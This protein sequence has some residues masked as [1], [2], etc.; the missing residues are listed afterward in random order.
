[1]SPPLRAVAVGIAV[2]L[3][4]AVSSGLFGRY[5]ERHDAERAARATV[6]RERDLRE[7][8]VSRYLN[9]RHFPAGVFAGGASPGPDG[10]PG[11]RCRAWFESPT[12]DL[13]DLYAS[14]P[15]PADG[16]WAMKLLLH[17]TGRVDFT[18]RG[19]LRGGSD[20]ERA[21]AQA[22]ICTQINE[23]PRI[24]LHASDPE[25]RLVHEAIFR[26]LKAVV[27]FRDEQVAV[28]DRPAAPALIL[29]EEEGALFAELGDL[30]IHFRRAGRHLG[31]E[32]VER[33]AVDEEHG[34][35]ERGDG[36]SAPAAALPADA[37]VSPGD[38]ARTVIVKRAMVNDSIV[39][40]VIPW[41]ARGFRGPVDLLIGIDNTERITGVVV[42]RERET[43][44]HARRAFGPAAGFPAG[45]DGLLYNDLSFRG[46]GR[47]VVEA[48]T[49][50]TVTSR[51]VLN[52]VRAAL[53]F[54]ET[55]N[56][57]EYGSEE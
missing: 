26:I 17:E 54:N 21:L 27:S 33:I 44:L 30:R 18:T 10:V 53:R 8:L 31:V 23:N 43:P 40:T 29:I 41:R 6:R 13:A 19:I 56:L 25:A 32:R 49:G 16:E 1:M 57:E 42:T 51:G 55:M 48:V 34:D 3:L 50:A 24:S 7:A 9:L 37:P 2:A 12:G 47:G 38:R 14:T 11:I 20:E 22:R 28:V 36:E 5:L 46:E 15:L 35:G 45:F 4:L 39:G 52:A